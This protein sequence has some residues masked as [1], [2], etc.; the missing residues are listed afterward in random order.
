MEG[1]LMRLRLLI[2]CLSFLAAGMV[3]AQPVLAAERRMQQNYTIEVTVECLNTAIEALRGLAG[4]NLHS[5]V[6]YVEPHTGLPLRQAF[7]TRRVENWAFRHVQA[8][9][10]ELGEVTFESEHARHLGA[11]LA[12]LET[13]LAVLSREVER[14]SIM[15]AASTTLDVLIAIDNRISQVTWE[16][17]HLTGRRNQLM[18]ESQSTLMQIRFVEETEYIRPEEPGFGRRVADSFLGSWNGLLRTGGNLV[19][20]FVRVSIPL[21]LWVVLGSVALL[22]TYRATKK[23]TVKKAGGEA[24]EP[25]EGAESDDTG[26]GDEGNE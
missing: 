5:G 16:R 9:L 8:V 2:A 21:T 24:A 11:E 14:L 6:T 12:G 3:F 23:R 20:F 10:R 26:N 25:I 17:N 13:R 15:M 4:H 19:V 1:L 18:A 7:Y 22:I